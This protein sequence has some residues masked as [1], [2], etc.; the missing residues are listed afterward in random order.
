M[1]TSKEYMAFILDQLSG[2]D[3]IQSRMMMGEYLI[4]HH[5]KI[6]AYMCDDRMMVK[7]LPSTL[8]LLPDA[9]RDKP[10]PRGKEM[11]VVD[12]VDDRSFLKLLFETMYPELPELQRKQKRTQR[13]CP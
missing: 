6:A 3:G 10:Y 4:Y 12:N 8:A 2:I 1:A 9:V 5:G 7:I 13:S 11:L